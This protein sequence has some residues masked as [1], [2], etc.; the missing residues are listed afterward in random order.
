MCE[1][2]GLITGMAWSLS[3]SMG[4]KEKR[5]RERKQAINKIIKK[6]GVSF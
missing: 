6:M 1:G 4:K 2:L 5:E 3:I